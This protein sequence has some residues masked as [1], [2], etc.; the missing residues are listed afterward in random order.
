MLGK[1]LIKAAGKGEYWIATLDGTNLDSGRSV[2]VDSLN[3][4]YVCGR[5]RLTASG[6]DI[7][8][9]AKYNASGALQWQR[10]YQAVVSSEGDSLA[11]DGS[12]NVYIC[13]TANISTVDRIIVA[14]YNSLGAVQWQRQLFPS[15]GNASG[16]AVATDDSG[17][18]YV[19]GRTNENSQTIPLIAKF[20]TTGTIQWQRTLGISFTTPSPN[21]ITVDDSGNVY[22]CGQYS[23]DIFF[24]KYNSSGTLQ[25]QKTINALGSDAAFSIKIDS[26]GDVYICGSTSSEGQGNFDCWLAKY[27]SSGVVQW[28]RVLGSASSDGAYSVAVDGSGG[29]Y[30]TGL[31]DGEGVIAKYNS[32]GVIQWQR[33]LSRSSLRGRSLAIDGL[34]NVCFCGESSSSFV[35]AR[36]PSD[37][38]LT[39]TYQGFVYAA[40]SFVDSS[41]SLPDSTSSFGS[42]TSTLTV[43]STSLTELAGNLVP[44]FIP[45]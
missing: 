31:A 6:P 23:L 26:S 18:V 9:I 44:S 43:S 34:G 16:F 25:W 35:I 14:K 28:Q 10:T 24:A 7:S 5:T 38:S 39:G 30:I 8:A 36:L 15:L 13:G 45:M 21:S 4:I 3:N 22:I 40:S 19:L 42:S 32:S 29:V 12:G 27:N 17:N 1:S 41:A 2:A 11:V 33:S 20:D 37:G